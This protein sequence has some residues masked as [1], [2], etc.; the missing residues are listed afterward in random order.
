MLYRTSSGDELRLGIQTP[1]VIQIP[2]GHAGW[3]ENASVEGLRRVVVT[4]DRLGYH[5]LTCSEHVAVP[6]PAAQVR[7][8]VYWDPV[9]TLSWA[10]ASTSQIQ[11]VTNVVVLGYHHPLEILKAYGTVDL[12]SG[13]RVILGVGVGTLREE[14]D[15]LGSPFEGRGGRADEALLAIRAGWGERAVE[16]SGEIFRYGPMI[17]EPHAPRRD[18]RIWVGG[19]TRRSLRRAIELADGWTPFGLSNRSIAAMLS[20]CDPPPGFDVVLPVAKPLDPVG[21]AESAREI[22]DNLAA[23]GATAAH[24]SFVHH[25]LGHFLE[26]LEALAQMSGSL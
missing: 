25:S 16:Y 18:V 1:V 24:A 4:A 8:G 7:G 2:A 23:A 22:L 10:A 6:L 21:D 13:G 15:L 12:L 3:E 19:S 26:Q 9:A 20:E 11:L 5:H 14:F 17:V